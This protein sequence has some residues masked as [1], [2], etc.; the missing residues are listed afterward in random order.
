MEA[1]LELVAA[2]AGDTIA[3]RAVIASPSF[4]AGLHTTPFSERLYDTVPLVRRHG[5]PLSRATRELAR[6][7]ENTIRELGHGLMT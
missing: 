7:A 1:A 5:H 4:P 2:G 6:L 3:G